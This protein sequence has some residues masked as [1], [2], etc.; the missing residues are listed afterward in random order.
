M[1]FNPF[2]F[3]GSQPQ[4]TQNISSGQAT[5]LNNFEFLADTTGNATNGFIQFPNGIIVQWCTY[6]TSI[7]GGA[8]P[9]SLTFTGIGMQ[10]AFPNN[11]FIVIPIYRSNSSPNKGAACISNVN[12][13]RTGFDLTS[14]SSSQGM[15]FVAIGN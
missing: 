8:A 7:T 1:S 9:L 10:A 2:T 15:Y 11:C 12:L 4:P 14:D 6:T 3:N 5:I 13:T